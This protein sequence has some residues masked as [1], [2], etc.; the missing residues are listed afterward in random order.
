[1]LPVAGSRPAGA[2]PR[3]ARQVDRAGHPGVRQL[4]GLDQDLRQGRLVER[5]GR[6]GGT[7]SRMACWGARRRG[8]ETERGA[9]G[10]SAAGITSSNWSEAA[11][12]T[13]APADAEPRPAA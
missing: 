8:V 10:W 11:A 12:A 3:T 2:S 9:G 7:A 1:M 6:S 4:A 13:R 5:R